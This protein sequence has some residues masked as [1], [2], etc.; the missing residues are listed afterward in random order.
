MCEDDIS[1][2][3]YIAVF[4]SGIFACVPGGK[5]QTT[6]DLQGVE[7]DVRCSLSDFANLSRAISM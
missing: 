4:R 2:V 3:H 7:I 6:D 5:V 1:K